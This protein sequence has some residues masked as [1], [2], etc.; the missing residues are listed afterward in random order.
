MRENIS[1]GREGKQKIGRFR[2]D[3]NTVLQT[4]D[5]GSEF[6]RRSGGRRT[7][8]VDIGR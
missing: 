6:R 8:E 5:E 1:E 3:R 2:K 7:Q 4:L